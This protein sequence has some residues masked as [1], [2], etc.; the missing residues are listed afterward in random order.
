MPFN[1]EPSRVD[2][3]QLDLPRPESLGAENTG[4]SYFHDKIV[5]N[6]PH[7]LLGNVNVNWVPGA[8]RDSWWGRGG[9]GGGPRVHPGLRLG[10]KP[11]P[12][13][14]RVALCAPQPCSE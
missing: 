10:P 8:G 11:C 2:K 3:Q 12:F 13:P 5:I 1:L 9:R 7:H 14:Y 6:S 4:E